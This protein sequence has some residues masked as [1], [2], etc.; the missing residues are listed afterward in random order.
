MNKYLSIFFILLA[1]LGAFK[2]LFNGDFNYVVIYSN[3][4]IGLLFQILAKLNGEY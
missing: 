3:L 4:I 1:G 2:G